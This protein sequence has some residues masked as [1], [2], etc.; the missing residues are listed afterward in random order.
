[1]TGVTNAVM[2]TALGA[3]AINSIY[4]YILLY[5]VLDGLYIHN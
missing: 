5:F 3:L 1:V 4:L 2:V